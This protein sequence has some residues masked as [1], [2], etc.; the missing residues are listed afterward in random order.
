M[1]EENDKCLL[2]NVGKYK[3]GEKNI[4]ILAIECE[5]TVCKVLIDCAL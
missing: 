3:D 2:L 4:F 1:E 5:D